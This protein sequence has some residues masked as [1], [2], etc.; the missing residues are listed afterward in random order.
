M[1]RRR[2]GVETSYR[3]LGEGLAKTTTKCTAWRMMLIAVAL[4]LRNLWVWRNQQVRRGPVTLSM[5]LHQLNLQL[6]HELETIL[7]FEIG[8]TSAV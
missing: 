1:Y 2:F 4:L 6:S 5:Q 3:Q 8:K 7:D